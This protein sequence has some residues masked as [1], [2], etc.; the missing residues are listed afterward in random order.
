MQAFSNNEGIVPNL[1]RRKR[2]PVSSS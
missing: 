1:H 2:G